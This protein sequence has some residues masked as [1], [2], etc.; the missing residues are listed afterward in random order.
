MGKERNIKTNSSIPIVIQYV[1]NTRTAGIL[2]TCLAKGL[3]KFINQT[4][5]ICIDE[6]NM[7]TYME[8]DWK[9]RQIVYENSMPPS[10]YL[11]DTDFPIKIA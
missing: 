8:R 5:S 7:V 2:T 3:D 4:G 6:N 1:P 9:G 11:R 10:K